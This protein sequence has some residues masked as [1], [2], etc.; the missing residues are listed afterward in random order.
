[1]EDDALEAAEAER[2]ESQRE[3]SIVRAS[4]GPGIRVV[5]RSVF[6]RGVQADVEKKL[7]GEGGHQFVSGRRQLGTPVREKFLSE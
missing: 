7:T 5:D 2:L 3:A 6:V 4:R 1:M